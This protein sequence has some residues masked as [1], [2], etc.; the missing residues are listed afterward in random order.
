MTVASPLGGILGATTCSVYRLDPTGTV[1]LE[2]I[3]D[4]VPGVF[5]PFRVTLDIVDSEQMASECDVTAH[6]VQ[7]FFDVT[8]HVHKRLDMLNITGTLGAG[9][10]PLP[11]QGPSAPSAFARLDLLRVKNLRA[12]Q[13]SR[14]P[15]MVVT[16]RNSLA[17]CFLASVVPSWTSADGERTTI[18]LG[19]IEARLVSPLVGEAIVPDFPEQSAG[20][21]AA[22]GGGQAQTAPVGVEGFSDGTPGVAPDVPIAAGFEGGL[23]P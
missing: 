14:A 16:P 23:A 15:L 11:F 17:K 21:N 7:D 22:S 8:S 4:L 20:N 13:A 10:K 12:L 2:P 18:S 19:F 3:P 6:P 5:T 9:L 1:P